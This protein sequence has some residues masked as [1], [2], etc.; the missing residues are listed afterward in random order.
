[1]SVTTTDWDPWNLEIYD[2]PYATYLALLE[3][4]PLY[5]N[6]RHGFYVL[7]RY[8]DV[9]RM[10]HDQAT[11]IAS[12]GTVLDVMMTGRTD[13]APGLFSFEDPPFHTFH[14]AQLSRVFTP[15]AISRIHEEVR[16]YCRRTLDTLAGRDRFDMMADFAREVPMRVMGLLL[17][18]PEDDQP[19][20]RDYFLKN[21][22]RDMSTPADN[23]HLYQAFAEYIDWREEHPSEDLM[24]QLLFTEF[25]DQ[26]GTVRRLTRDELLTYVNLI[27]AAG[28]DTTGL[29]IGWITKLLAD[30]PDQRH[31]IQRDP[32]LIPNAVEEVVRFEPPPYVFGRFVAKDVEIHGETVPDGAKIVCIPGAANRD[33][34]HFGPDAASFDIHRKTERHLSFGYGPHFCLG[35]NLARL[36]GRI[37]LEEL[38]HRIPDWHVD[39]EARLVRGGPTRGYEYLP[40]A[41]GDAA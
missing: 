7:S 19:I 5:Y 39:G 27:G 23:A 8:D 18:I 40:V 38:L 28:N 15:R 16:E 29:L 21:L 17:G 10:L 37:A 4:A 1:V 31:Q 20:L 9:E 25:E 3:E 22:H 12:K 36:E 30:H 13:F 14:R 26:T 11:F 6:E 33:P 2:D 41:V 32:D 24:T 34:N 35:A